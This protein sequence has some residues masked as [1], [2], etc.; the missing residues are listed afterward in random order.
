MSKQRNYG[1]A[2]RRTIRKLSGCSEVPSINNTFWD[3]ITPACNLGP[4]AKRLA[5]NQPLDII[6]NDYNSISPWC[7][8][9]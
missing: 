3:S 6:R 1:P 4:E 9:S 8:F 2:N 5:I 7:S